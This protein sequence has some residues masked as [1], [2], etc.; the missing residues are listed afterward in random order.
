MI[1]SVL[2]ILFLATSTLTIGQVIFEKGYYLDNSGKRI[3]GLIRNDDWR[4]NPSRFYYKENESSASKELGVGESGEF[5]LDKGIRFIR[6]TVDIDYSSDVDEINRN[7]EGAVSQLSRQRDPEWKRQTVYLQV[8]VD[9]YADLFYWY[10]EGRSRFFYRVANSPI[11]QLIS[12]SYLKDNDESRAVVVGVNKP[13]S[14]FQQLRN[15]DYK[16]QLFKNAICGKIGLE[17]VKAIDYKR[18]D[19]RLYFVEINKCFGA[20]YTDNDAAAPRSRKI[21]L[22]I[23]PGLNFSSYEI[24]TPT[25]FSTIRSSFPLATTFR[26]GAELEYFVRFSANHWSLLAEPTYRTYS[27]E[28][29]RGTAKDKVNYTSIELPL[30]VRYSIYLNPDSRIFLNASFVLDFALSSEIAIQGAQTRTVSSSS[31]FAFGAGIARKKLSAEVRLF[32]GRNLLK[33]FIAIPNTFSNTSLIFGY[34]LF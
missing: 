29:T 13:F 1:K 19:L 8:V 12:K 4:S 10:G 34:T 16:D 33:D 22:N 30:G 9:G 5:G 14:S 25:S 2:V 18:E 27:Q 26:L 23:R 32:T 21:Q 15:D 11:A 20:Q 17:R 28:F 24:E 3:D 7:P 31:N 6:E